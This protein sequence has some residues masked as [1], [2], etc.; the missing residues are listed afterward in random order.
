MMNTRAIV[1]TLTLI[2]S[3]A[4][5]LAERNKLKPSDFEPLTSLPWKKPDATLESVLDFIFREP[6]SGIRYP[7]L[8]DYLRIVP[9]EELGKAFDLC[10][11][12]EGTQ[13]PDALIDL[14]LRIW[15]KRE[16]VTCWQRTKELFRLVGV[17]DGWLNYDDWTT[18]DRITVQDRDAIQASRFWIEH[19]DV[20]SSFAFG[21]DESALPRE[22]RV[23]LMKE[24]MDVW[25]DAFGTWPGHGTYGSDYSADPH[26][27][28]AAGFEVP[29]D[30][31]RHRSF[32]NDGVD[33]AAAFEIGMRRWLEKEP[34]AALEII[35]KVGEKK[36]RPSGSSSQH[37]NDGPSLEL[38]MVWAK[39]DLPAMIRWVD[40]LDILKDDVAAQAKG[41]LMSRVEAGTRNR[42]FA[43]VKPAQAGQDRS[44]ALLSGWAG[45]DPKAALDAAIATKDPDTIWSV[46][47]KGA[48]GPFN[49]Q[50]WN[51]SHFGIGVIKDFEVARLPKVLLKEVIA[52]W[53]IAIMEQWGDIDIGEAARYGVDFLLRTNY[54]PRKYLIKLFSGDDKFSSDSD[55]IDRTFCALR[56]WAVVKPREMKAWIATIKE[57]DMRKA[58]TWLLEHPWGTGPGPKE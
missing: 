43:D 17:E 41:F 20:L 13:T 38:L 31:L 22:E 55:M 50:P 56:V 2:S 5:A 15:A 42:W 24:F 9:V 49:D 51:S 53:G 25:L 46:A 48:Y 47:Q 16:P 45:W 34:G 11:V 26:G 1:V 33:E 7:L 29:A 57:A 36:W 44:E 39:A 37:L 21:V 4:N 14:F 54:A 32:P 30:E 28:V 58:L 12:L 8:A 19:R 3:V 52:E 40:S 27:L 6:N 10:I 23:R 18:R 35:K